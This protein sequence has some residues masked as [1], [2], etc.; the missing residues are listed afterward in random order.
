MYIN[1][2]IFKIPIVNSVI[3]YDSLTSTNDIIKSLIGNGA[4]DGTLIIANE[5]T[6]GKGR[7]GRR[8]SSPSGE[9]IYFSLLV[10]PDLELS[11]IPQMTIIAAMAVAKA[12][13]SLDGIS[14]SIKW[15]NDIILDSKKV[16]GILTECTGNNVIIGIGINVNNKNFPDELKE[17]ATSLYLTTGHTYNR[18]ELVADVMKHFN[19]Y[20]QLLLS[21]KDLSPVQEEYNKMLVNMNSEIYAIPQAMSLSSNNPDEI[22]KAGLTPAICRGIDSHGALIVENADGTLNLLNSG[23]VSIRTKKGY[24]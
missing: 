7:L 20:Y 13:N 9:G 22:D 1:N 15:P 6:K 3:M 8:F 12:L 5:Q 4:V 14:V 11:H 10:M 19:Q 24:C 18:E 21:T 2:S 17:H 23:E 16:V